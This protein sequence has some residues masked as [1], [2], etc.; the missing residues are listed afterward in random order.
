MKGTYTHTHFKMKL[1]CQDLTTCPSPRN[2][3]PPESPEIIS[4]HDLRHNSE[5]DTTSNTEYSPHVWFLSLVYLM[6]I[7]PLQQLCGAAHIEIARKNSWHI[8]RLA[9]IF[10]NV[11][12]F[13]AQT[14]AIFFL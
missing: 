12:I 13:Y 14:Y 7:K 3:P 2:N 11:Y 9:M 10:L 1:Y 6:Y 5:R 4:L 8:V